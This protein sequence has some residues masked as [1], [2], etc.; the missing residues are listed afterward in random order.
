MIYIYILRDVYFILRDVYFVTTFYFHYFI[1]SY[2]LSKL[3]ITF[4]GHVV[5]TL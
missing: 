3:D 4:S 5:R 1:F 2:L